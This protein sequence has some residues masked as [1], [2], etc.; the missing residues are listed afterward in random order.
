MT[1]EIRLIHKL[2]REG[3]VID[4]WYEMFDTELGEAVLTPASWSEIEDWL[5]ENE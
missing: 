4:S 3:D 5:A 2:N 1:Y